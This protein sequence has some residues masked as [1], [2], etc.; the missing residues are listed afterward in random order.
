M[1][2]SVIFDDR[3]QIGESDALES[4]AALECSLANSPEVFVADDA[5][6]GGTFEE[7]LLFDDFE[8]VGEGDTRE[9]RAIFEC[10]NS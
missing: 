2:E 5:L 3:E 8:L 9:G 1:V 7:H 4:I 6:E 10:A